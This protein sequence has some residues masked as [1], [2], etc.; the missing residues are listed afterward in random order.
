MLSELFGNAGSSQIEVGS[1]GWEDEDDYFFPGEETNDGHTLVRVQLFRGRDFTKGEPTERAQGVKLICHIP[2]GNFRVPTKG[3]RC[4]V[5]IP[6]GL[7]SLVGAGTVI[8]TVGGGNEVR[9]N[10]TAGDTVIAPAGEDPGQAMII[11]K[12]SDGSVTIHTT[13]NNDTNG[14]SIF[15]RVSPTAFQF[16]APWG[17][18]IFDASGVHWTTKS[19]ARFDM[20]G[21]SIPGLPGPIADAFGSYVKLTAATVKCAGGSVYLGQGTYYQPVVTTLP[22]DLN[23]TP[24]GIATTVPGPQP[25]LVGTPS[26]WVSA[27]L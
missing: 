23:T 2:D 16:V 15:F 19:G 14:N 21:I 7:D 17:R 5:A 22:T 3:A 9:R 20:G 13:D 11:A 24:L 18:M 6:Q 4:L 8:A 12:A 1:I 26:V 10:I 27:T 25:N